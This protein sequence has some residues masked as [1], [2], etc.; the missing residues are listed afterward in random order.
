[1]NTKKKKESKTRSVR[2]PIDIWKIIANAAKDEDRSVNKQILY[3]T[4]QWLERHNYLKQ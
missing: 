2:F 4:K 3:I 1:M